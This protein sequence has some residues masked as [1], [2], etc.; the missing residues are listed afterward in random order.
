M[1]SKIHSYQDQWG[2]V[3]TIPRVDICAVCNRLLASLQVSAAASFAQL[4]ERLTDVE[5]VVF[6]EFSILDQL[7]FR[8]KA[9]F[10]L[11]FSEYHGESSRL[12]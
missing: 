7:L 2:V 3:E 10:N 4:V 12:Q 9:S 8:L 11:I 5:R 1:E 6:L